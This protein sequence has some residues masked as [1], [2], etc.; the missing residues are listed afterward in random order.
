MGGAS[1]ARRSQIAPN[2]AATRAAET[3]SAAGAQEFPPAVAPPVTVSAVPSAAA[4]PQQA[5]S[6]SPVP[7]PAPSLS[8]TSPLP[9][10]SEATFQDIKDR[11]W[12]LTELSVGFGRV[13]FDRIGMENNGHGDVYI[14]QFADEGVNG[15][16]APNRYFAPYEVQEGHSVALRTIVGT[17]M[18]ASINIGGIMETEFYYYL[19]R[20]SRWD[21]QNGRLDLFVAVS[22]DENAVLS[23]RAD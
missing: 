1:S 16:A 12:K 7:V 2:P 9:S 8:R 14:I 20:I 11:I 6:A 19:Q 21:L 23:F 17:M 3:A 15:K 10:H 22:P 13:V 4:V 18:A 5:E